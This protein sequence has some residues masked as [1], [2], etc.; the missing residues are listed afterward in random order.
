MSLFFLGEDVLF[1]ESVSEH[2]DSLAGIS[3]GHG[4]YLLGG[5]SLGLS[6]IPDIL[7]EHGVGGQGLDALCL[8]GHSSTGHW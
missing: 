2:F 5:F 1:S 4:L 8:A 6:S 7:V 3:V